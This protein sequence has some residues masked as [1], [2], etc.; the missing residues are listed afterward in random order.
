MRII[1]TVSI[2]AMCVDAPA[3]VGCRAYEM[4]P[5]LS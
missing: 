1:A 5:R 4:S 2:V 3:A